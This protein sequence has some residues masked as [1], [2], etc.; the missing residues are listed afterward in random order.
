MSPFPLPGAR[1]Q[2]STLHLAHKSYHHHPLPPSALV[3]HNHGSL[4]PEKNFLPFPKLFCSKTSFPRSWFPHPELSCSEPGARV[5]SP[6][7]RQTS[8]GTGCLTRASYLKDSEILHFPSHPPPPF[9]RRRGAALI[10]L[11][12]NHKPQWKEAV[13]VY[14]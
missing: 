1:F 9:T 3:P 4:W 14:S 12:R 6:P 10:K 7:F 2:G 13:L 11:R 8:G 5:A